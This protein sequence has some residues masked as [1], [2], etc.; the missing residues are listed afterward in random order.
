MSTLHKTDL[1]K[2]IAHEAGLTYKDSEAALNALLDTVT[3]SLAKGDDVSLL[4]F[5]KF[6]VRE[7]A[8]RKGRNPQTGKVMTIAARKAPAFKAGKVL[9]EKVRN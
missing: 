7:R 8:A 1:V 9:K 5:G 3:N 6:E 2:A 4:G